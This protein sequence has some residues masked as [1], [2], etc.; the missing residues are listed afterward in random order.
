MK[1]SLYEHKYTIL[2]P[3]GV[4]SS[5][6]LGNMY[7][8]SCKNIF[9]FFFLFYHIIVA[10]LNNLDSRHHHHQLHNLQLVQLLKKRINK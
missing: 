7:S 5:S 3:W 4:V 1:D 2:L 6:N 8:K 10:Y 9:L